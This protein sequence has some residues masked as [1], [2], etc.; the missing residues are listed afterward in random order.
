MLNYTDGQGQVKHGKIITHVVLSVVVVV[1]LF[2]SFGTIKAG[3]VGVKTTL[4]AVSGILEPGFYLK[5]PFLQKVNR[6]NVKTLT[7]NYDR[8]GNEGD[9]RDSSELAGASSDLQ[10]VGIAVVVNYHIDANKAQEIFTQY[11]STENFELNVIEPIIRET[12]KTTSGEYTAE[13]LVTKRADYSDK[14]NMRLKDKFSEKNAVLERFSVTNFQFSPAF[15]QAIE[16]KVTAVQN[17]E[18]AKNKLVQVQFEAQQQVE[19]AKAEAETIRIQAQAITQQGGKDY[20]QLKALE[21][22][23]GKLPTQMIPGSAVPFLDLN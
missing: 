12:V 21:K 14:V 1:L 10:D 19:R 22:W 17:A 9:S 23:D 7:V 18:A 15:T 11:K 8:N 20:V 13:E 16:A 5:A 6:I 4:G 3:E 2:S